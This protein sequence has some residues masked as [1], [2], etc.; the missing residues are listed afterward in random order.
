MFNL[1]VLLGSTMHRISTVKVQGKGDAHGT[2]RVTLTPNGGGGTFTIDATAD[3]GAR[4]TGHDHVR[5]ICEAGW[6]TT[7]RNCRLRLTTEVTHV[8]R[9]V[10]LFESLNLF[11]YPRRAPSELLAR[12][13]FHLQNR[14]V[15]RVAGRAQSRAAQHDVFERQRHLVADGFDDLRADDGQAVDDAL[16]QGG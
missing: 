5:R 15:A 3:T 2:G 9:Q 1:G 4:I 12:N 10:E 7:D 6:K 14:L 16:A 11:L 13:P 8:N